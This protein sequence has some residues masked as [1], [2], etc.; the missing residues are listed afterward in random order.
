VV[1]RNDPPEAGD[2]Q[3]GRNRVAER[4]V[5]LM[6]LGNASGGKGPQFRTDVESK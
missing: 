5:L 4:F 2:G 3:A 1:E 6:K